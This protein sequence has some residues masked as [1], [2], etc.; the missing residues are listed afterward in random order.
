V[1][2]S[3]RGF[4]AALL[5]ALAASVALPAHAQEGDPARGAELGVTCLGCHGIPGYRN[6]Y[7]SFRVPKLGGQKPEYVKAAL[8]AYRAGT[9]SHPTMQAHGSALSEQD[10]ADIAAWIGAGGTAR[11][12]VTA[13]DLSHI[14]AGQQCIACHSPAGENATPAPPVL[15]GQHREYLEH[16]LR[17]YREQ[18]RGMTVMNAFA[19]ALS[20]EDIERL[21]EFYSS[22]AGLWTLEAG[23]QTEPR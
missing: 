21:A 11:D 19:G 12:E 14:E 15:S 1:K 20:D 7:P 13:D 22:R 8:E 4:F 5:A 10:I 23:E 6:A 2:R 16:A 3:T 18:A 9:R 17:R